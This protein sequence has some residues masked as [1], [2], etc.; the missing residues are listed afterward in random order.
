MSLKEEK[1]DLLAPF[2]RNTPE[3]VLEDCLEASAPHSLAYVMTLG[4]ANAADA[5]EVLCVGYI[6]N[7]IDSL[8]KSEKGSTVWNI[9]VTYAE[10]LSAAVY[11]GMFCGGILCGVISDRIG[12]KP[13]LQYALL[14]NSLAALAS[15]FSPNITALIIFRVIAGVGIGATMPSVF[16]MSAEVFPW[17]VR[18]KMISIVVRYTCCASS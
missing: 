3:S 6:M 5:V 8:S 7:E 13:C 12:R 11:M 15:A 1:R 17:T 9:H 16:G 4:F 2:Q 14:V 10:N 18:G